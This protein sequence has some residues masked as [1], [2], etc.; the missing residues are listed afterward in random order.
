MTSCENDPRISSLCVRSLCLAVGRSAVTRD[1]KRCLCD[2]TPFWKI[3]LM[4]LH[5]R[6]K[7]INALL[8][9]YLHVCVGGG[10]EFQFYLRLIL[11][12]RNGHNHFPP[13]LQSQQCNFPFFLFTME[14]FFHALKIERRKMQ[15]I[16]PPMAAID[17]RNPIPVSSAM[18]HF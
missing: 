6:Q 18:S 2:S 3:L 4:L 15:I 13:V 17:C 10:T 16:G 7:G 1:A 12:A 11:V 5:N 14:C 9:V 8:P